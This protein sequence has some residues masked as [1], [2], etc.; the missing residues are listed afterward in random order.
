M[1]NL[2]GVRDSTGRVESKFGHLRG[3]IEYLGLGLYLRL[4]LKCLST[5]ILMIYDL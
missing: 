4:H 3:I 1:F 5:Y 2:A